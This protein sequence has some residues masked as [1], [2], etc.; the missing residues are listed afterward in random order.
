VEQGRWY[1]GRWVPW[2]L[3]A[4]V[5]L[6]A[7]LGALM[8][9]AGVAPFLVMLLGLFVLGTAAILLAIGIKGQRDRILARESQYRLLAENA[10]DVVVLVSLDGTLEWI[11]PSVTR[12]LGYQPEG[13][14]GTHPWD[15]VHPDDRSAAAES[16][17]AAATPGAVPM[18]LAS[19][20]R[21]SDG[22]YMWL[23]AVGSK[24]PDG[25]FVV[26]F[27]QVDEQVRVQQAL[28]ESE[29]HYRLL[30][31]NAMD[32]VFSLDMHAKIEWV[33]PSAEQML[34]YRPND[35]VGQFGGMLIVDEDLPLL[36]DAATKAR[37]GLPES[38]Q[39]RMRTKSGDERWVEATPRTL[40]D[41]NGELIGG[42]I[43]VR[44]I[45]EEVVARTALAHASDY[46][47]LT[48]LAQPSLALIRLQDVI[49][50]HPTPDWALV[51]IG[52]DGMT[53]IN[54]AYTYAAGDAVLV[55]VAA[56]LV[57]AAGDVDNLARIAGDEFMVLVSD[58]EDATE[59][60]A[61]AA[62]MLDAV[63]GPVEFDDVTIDVT[64]CAGIALAHGNDA[65]GLLRD[66]TAAMRQAA[67]RGPDRW[68]FLDGDVEARTRR[69][70]AVQASLREG[71]RAG[72]LE[73]WFMP[74]VG[75]S[76]GQLIGY[77]VLARLVRP[78]GSIS[79]PA[80]FLKG[81]ERTG[82][83]V[84]IDQV[85]L[86]RA[87]ALLHDED[88]IERLAVNV[89]AATLASGSLTTRLVDLLQRVDVDLRRLHLEVTE[90]SL[91]TVTDDVR[92]TMEA[93]AGL[94]VSWWVDDF[95]TGFSSISHLR[96]LPIAGLKLD[97]SFTRMLTLDDTPATRLA[98]GLVGLA[99]GLG[100]QTIAEGVETLQQKEVLSQQG[101]T[102]GQGW[103]F[104]RPLPSIPTSA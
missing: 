62:R 61:A 85:M 102:Y 41:D 10:S 3:A 12:L 60:A 86:E 90:T 40:L 31:E 30:A 70:L 16:L 50:S 69:E 44:D 66:S 104:G 82:L 49:D 8:L 29:T 77:E 76:D 71:I 37:E 99:E 84:S 24:A 93:I 58:V 59:A 100:L 101:W 72:R 9:A 20:F 17:A 28:V 103:L 21:K 98:L 34:G 45:H 14:V 36:L 6:L 5:L 13:L 83:I 97:Q 63:R 57:E 96:D 78:D 65:Q 18:P 48:G 19:R 1:E 95:G 79:L 89:S 38:C 35:L 67:I 4:L 80:E 32:M 68:E 2:L 46:D 43:G 51:C 91:F 26:S 47:V 81:A 39:I 11:S 23:A 92:R 88:G 55:A 54:Q 25:P 52:V 15:L 87:L 33:S 56:R 73:P 94:G 7:G 42:V 22:S 64:A 53:A 75:L 27:R 74:I